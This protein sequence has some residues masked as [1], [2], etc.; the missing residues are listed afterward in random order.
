MHLL[1]S[2]E[3]LTLLQIGDYLGG[4]DHSTVL[5]ACEKVD[6][7]LKQNPSF[8]S[9]YSQIRQQIYGTCALA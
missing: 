3:D 9:K 7:L 5:H 2:E 1:R 4:W 6:Q 8:F